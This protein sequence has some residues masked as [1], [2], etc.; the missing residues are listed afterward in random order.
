MKYNPNSTAKVLKWTISHPPA[1]PDAAPLDH[2]EDVAASVT[3]GLRH[4]RHGYDI[5]AIDHVA[6]L[7]MRLDRWHTAV[8]IDERYAVI[9][10]AIVVH[11]LE[12]DTP[13]HRND[14]VRAGI[15]ASDNHARENMRTHGRDTT[16]IGMPMQAFLKYWAPQHGASPE[17]RTVE[18]H[19]VQQIW[20]L[21]RPSEQRALAALAWFEDYELA[22]EACGVEVKTFRVLISTGRRRFL[23]LWHEGEAPSRIWRTDRRVRSRNGKDHLGR[24]RLTVSQVDGYRERYQAG[25]RLRALGAEA[26]VS[27][28]CLS[29]LIRGIS[30][31]APEVAR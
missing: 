13:P 3:S 5:A 8:D 15:T 26:G 6:R 9:R 30:K 17:G 19:A 28:T 7:T 10:H 27:A 20:P 24:Q 2:F 21:L 25:E 22:A 18:R 29:N 1:E 23:A 14:L 12:A 4:V 16:R 11:L 31:P